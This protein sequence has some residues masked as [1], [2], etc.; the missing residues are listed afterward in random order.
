MVSYDAVVFICTI[1]LCDCFPSGGMGR[2]CDKLV[3]LK[4]YCSDLIDIDA[5]RVHTIPHKRII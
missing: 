1:I 5:N 4:C 2:K 3:F